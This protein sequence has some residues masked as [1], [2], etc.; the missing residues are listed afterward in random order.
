MRIGGLPNAL[1]S[2][3]ARSNSSSCC[4][5]V[6]SEAPN[7]GFFGLYGDFGAPGQ[8]V[9]KIG[10]AISDT[11]RLNFLRIA[12][13]SAMSCAFQLMMFLSCIAR[14]STQPRPNSFEATSHACAKSWEISSVITDSLNAEVSNARPSGSAATP[15]LNRNSRRDGI[16]ASSARHANTGSPGQ[17]LRAPLRA[18]GKLLTVAV[19]HHAVRGRDHPRVFRVGVRA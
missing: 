3:N 10:D 15:R 11:R 19:Q 8:S 6:K 5:N 16:P 4:S 9:L 2:A 18:Y 7:S 1:A 12:W 14:S 13:A 17:S